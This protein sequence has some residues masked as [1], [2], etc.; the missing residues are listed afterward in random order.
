[1]KVILWD[2]ETTPLVV[3]TWGLWGHNV[4]P[5]EIISDR[6]ILAIAWKELGKERVHGAVVGSDMSELEVVAAFRNAIEDADVLV[7][8]NSD[9]FDMRHLT[10]KLI[11]YGLDP[12]PKINTVDTLK[13]VRKIAKFSSNRLNFLGK[14]LIGQQKLETGRQLWV[15]CMAGDEKALRRMLRYCKNDVVLLEAVYM[16]LRPYMRSHPNLADFDSL[17]CPMCNSKSITLNKEYRTKAGLLRNHMRCNDCR[18][19]FTMRGTT[20]SPRPL[21][22]A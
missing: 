18:A 20:K 12:L 1:M 19:P 16:R 13:E 15:D 3:R 21:S 6:R 9:K 22:V 7:G 8:H 17:N 11:E 2:I 5:D 10:A 4:S 14:K